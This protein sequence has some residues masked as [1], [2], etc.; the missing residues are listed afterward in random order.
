MNWQQLLLELSTMG[1]A[2]ARNMRSVQEA[3]LS[4]SSDAALPSL[5][6][7]GLQHTTTNFYQL[8]RA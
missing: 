2:K 1:S 6:S 7:R 4:D 8:G 5:A 3:D